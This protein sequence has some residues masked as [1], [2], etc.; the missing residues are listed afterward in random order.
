MGKD[1]EG[2]DKTSFSNSQLKEALLDLK[3][4]LVFSF[5]VL[6]TMPSPVLTAC[7]PKLRPLSIIVI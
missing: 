3:T 6:V 7:E 1:R 5:G 2:G 4:W